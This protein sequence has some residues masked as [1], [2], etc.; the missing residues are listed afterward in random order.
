MISS[1]RRVVVTGMGVITAAGCDLG[2]FWQNLVS[3]TSFTRRLQRFDASAFPSRIGAEVSAEALGALPSLPEEWTHRGRIAQY[4]GLAARQAIDDA[5]VIESLDP[6]RRVGVSIAAGIAAFDHDEVI[7]SSADAWAVE[8]D[9]FDGPRFAAALRARLKPRAAERRNPGAIPAAIAQDYGFTGPVIAV[10]TA[11]AGGTQ[12]IGDALRWIRTG[13]ADVVVAGGSDSELSPLGLASFCLLGALTR[14]NDEPA[15]ASRP[16]DA[17]RDGFVLGEGAG[18]LVLEERERA[19]QRGARIYAEV[20]GFG[21]ASDAYRATDPHPD[22]LGAVLAMTRAL[23]AAELEPERVGYI[24][25]HGTST[26]ANDRIETLAI[27][28]QFGLHARRLAVSSTKSMIGHATV[29]AGAIEA[30]ATA[31]VL[32]HQVAHPTINLHNADPECDL[33]Y[34]PN[35]ARAISC[36]AAL[37]NSFAFGGQTACL[38]LVGHRA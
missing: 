21:S 27:K 17:S 13:V 6:A 38:A 9:R 25:A 28:R 23:E 26:V 34:V 19:L 30:I 2:T 16:F 24:N 4:A 33:D 37:S 5:R 36:E 3:G 20:A 15:R 29:A 11:C 35:R 14:H 18:A 12:A 7:G 32:Q 22:G 10:M 8:P 1:R 31:L